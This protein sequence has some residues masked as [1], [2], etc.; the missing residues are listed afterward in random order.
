M[1]L[2]ML[3]ALLPAIVVL[4][5]VVVLV[6]VLKLVLLKGAPAGAV[7]YEA[8][9]VFGILKPH[10]GQLFAVSLICS[11]HSGHGWRAMAQ[12]PRPK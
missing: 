7:P 1:P 11:P 6:G 2:G 5:I 12:F 9:E 3:D 8:A 10:R 4:V